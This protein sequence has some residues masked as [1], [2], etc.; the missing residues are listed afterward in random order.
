MRCSATSRKYEGKKNT[1][2]KPSSCYDLSA[3]DHEL[4][5]LRVPAP[6]EWPVHQ[7][8]MIRDHE[9]GGGCRDH[10]EGGGCLSYQQQQ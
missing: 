8:Q 5:R 1:M 7:A 2:S 6:K 3:L 10:E 9:E 4:H